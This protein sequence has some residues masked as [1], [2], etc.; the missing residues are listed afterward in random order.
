MPEPTYDDT[1]GTRVS[2]ARKRR[3]LTQHGL[4]E[5]ARY[6]RSHVAQV[7]AGHKV[8][9]PSFI[10]TVAS[11]LAVDPTELTGQPYRGE[12]ASD[13][14]V[15]A[16]IPEVRR[17]L[18]TVD[19]PGELE[20]PP[21][22]LD[23]LAEEVE[24]LR[25][26]S[27]AARHVQVGARLP[28]VLDEL[29]VH[30]ADSGTPR[31]WTL[32]NAA[33]AL[34]AALARRLGYNDLAAGAIRS[35]GESARRSDDPNLP[36]L[37]QLSR[38]LLL[39]T[40]GAWP[41]GLRLVQRAGEGM[42]TDTDAGRAVAGALRL[43]AAILSARA[44]EPSA[45]WEHYAQAVEVARHMPKQAPDFYAL[46]FNRANVALHGA[47]VA[48]ELRD[49]D[50]AV[51][52]DRTIDTTMTGL[53]PER[54]AH[55]E[56]DMARVYNETGDHDTALRRLLEAERVAPQMTRYHPSARVVIGHLVDVRRTIPEPLRGIQSR[57]RIA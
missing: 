11:V 5:R 32:L 10:A 18:E 13:D 50:Q 22:E 28:A 52:R 54:R 57:M 41:Q 36:R 7:E 15:H 16:T 2:R 45:A 35:A 55:H 56:I 47:A 44:D 51:K 26:L 43:R 31:A 1:I 3:A 19:I 39:L 25:R 17:A 9:T 38:A 20:A 6:S 37:A 46:Q 53:P 33:E 30:A 12:T 24:R 49:F 29:A 8:A 27:K 4:A 14:Q 34:A 23:T 48:V 40:F 42:D 21:R